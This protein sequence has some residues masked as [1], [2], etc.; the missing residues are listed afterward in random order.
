[1]EKQGVLEGTVSKQWGARDK[2]V[3]FRYIVNH[4]AEMAV[5]V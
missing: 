2:L 5:M 4:N 1:M 3:V